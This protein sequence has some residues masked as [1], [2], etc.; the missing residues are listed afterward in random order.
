V[1]LC[2]QLIDFWPG[3]RAWQ[4]VYFLGHIMILAI[5]GVSM[6]FPPPHKPQGKKGPAA[7]ANPQLSKTQ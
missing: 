7:D 4:S 5:M 3:W 6:L 1:L 2:V